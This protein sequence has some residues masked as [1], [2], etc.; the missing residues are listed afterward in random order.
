MKLFRSIFLI[1][2]LV[3][4][5]IK[6]FENASYES[7]KE[8]EKITIDFNPVSGNIKKEKVKYLEEPVEVDPSEQLI[9]ELESASIGERKKMI[10]D[11][12]E[13][14]HVGENIL[15]SRQKK[16]VDLFRNNERVDTTLLKKHIPRVTIRTLRRDLESL[17]KMGI[18]K[19]IG[20]TKGSYYVRA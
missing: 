19:K 20:E 7:K 2:G 5:I 10:D 8:L 13:K 11:L 15:S 9:N 4:L 6:I 18:V 12:S 14:L 16:I 17:G 1:G 3:F